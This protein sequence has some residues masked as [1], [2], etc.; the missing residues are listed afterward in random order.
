MNE[1]YATVWEAV[2]EAI[3]GREAAVHGATIRRWWQ[4]EA[5]AARLA[6]A[7]SELGVGP[8]SLVALDM[9]NC[10]E[11]LEA[12]FAAFKLRAVPFN[13]NYRFREAE[14][15]YVFSDANADV[16]LFDPA[17]TD[18][19][20]AAAATV[21]RPKHL[22]ACGRESP[23]P[24][25]LSME[26][27]IEAH[28]PAPRIER[29]GEDEVVIYTGGTT[30]HPK[31]VVWPHMA[32]MNQATAP[33]R[34]P[35]IAE[36]VEAVV[37]GPQS[38][39]L[40]IPPLMHGTGF[41]GATNALTSGG[42]VVFCES[43]SLDAREALCLVEEQ[44]ISS[45]SVVGDAVAKPLVAEL[46]RAAAEGRPYDLS[47]VQFVFST[48]VTWSA[49]VKKA[50]LRHGHFVVRDA[51]ASTEGSGFAFAETRQGEEVETARFR[52]GPNARVVN[53]RLHDVVPGSGE[54]GYLA[55]TGVLPKGY[56]NDP[57]RSART[58]PTIDGRRYAMPGDMAR[59][60][61]DGT[62]VLMRR[63]S[64]AINT[65]GETVFVEEVEHVI[66]SHAAI[67]DTVVVGLPDE[68]WG[69]RVSALVA[70]RP[71]ESLTERDVIEHVGGQL[72]D[73]K[74][75]RTVLFVDEVPR[76]PNGK[77]DRRHARVLAAKGVPS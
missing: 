68:R 25:V 22:V 36:H 39:A 69:T 42:C 28:D 3:G 10:I 14:L 9:W 66:L 26:D 77:A 40:V 52:L 11:N 15:A 44:R 50:L 55:T 17:F 8:G 76:S 61:E 70:L 16:V 4:F 5:R 43:R 57:E 74:R 64:E 59:V 35:T 6:S 20:A 62:V 34:P 75:P 7:L 56:L 18:R 49:P 41:F 58:W 67:H 21:G 48:G 72:A 65:G 19:V 12:L 33:P 30:G 71:G 38:R 45:F 46:E 13:V 63:G 23:A 31:G 29:S 73:Y 2:A 53:E 24:G 47:S 37:G 32:G 54:V 60:E 1:N 27:L 51:I